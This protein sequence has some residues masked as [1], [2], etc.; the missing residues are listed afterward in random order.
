MLTLPDE[1]NTL[2]DHF[3]AFFSKRI[4]TL[5]VVWLGGAFLAPG[6]RTVT[7]FLRILGLSQEQHFQIFHRVLDRAVW[8]N[9]ALRALCLGWLLNMFRPVGPVVIGIDAISARRR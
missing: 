8:S 6:N 3:R 4:G 2:F 9:L 5:A 1:Y 7:A